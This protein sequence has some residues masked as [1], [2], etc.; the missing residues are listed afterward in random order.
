V[1]LLSQ[2]WLSLLDSGHDHLFMILACILFPKFD[3]AYVANTCS[4]QPVETSTE[5]LDGDDVEIAGAGVVAAVH[6]RTDGKTKSHPELVTRGSTSS[7]FGRHLGQKLSEGVGMW[8][9]VGR[10]IRFGR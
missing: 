4:R 3:I 8:S 5:S 7:S 6:D 9:W 10:K 2:F 1:D